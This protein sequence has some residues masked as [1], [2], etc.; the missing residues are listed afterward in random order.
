MKQREKLLELIR[1]LAEDD[2]E[3]VMADKVL[4]L[5][6][7]L[8]HANDVAIDIMD[9]ALSAHIKIL[10]YSCTQYREAQKSRWLG[11][12][13]EELKT[14]STWVLPALKQIREICCLYQEA[15]HNTA[16]SAHHAQ[17]QGSST[18]YR[19][20]V[21]NNLQLDH[22][23][24]ILVADNLTSY[25]D[26]VR[27]NPPKVL[28]GNPEDLYPDGRYNHVIQVQE[29]LNFLRFL[30]KDGQLWLCA[31]QAKQIWN[32][33]AENAVFAQDREACFKWFSKLMGDEPDLDPEINRD[34]FENNI[35][36]LD[37]SLMTESGIKC[38][39]RFFKEV[40]RKE[41][42][43]IAKRRAYLMDDLELIGMDYIWR[44]VL[45]SNEEIANKAIELLKETFT[46]LGPRLQ[47]NQV[48]I[49]ED[50]ISSCFDRLKASYD[51][52][53]LL[54]QE[55]DVK[56]GQEATKLCRVLK[57]LHEYVQECDA[58]FCDERTLVPLFRASRGKQL[59]LLFRFP[60][61]GRQMDDLEIYT[62]TNDTLASVKRQ[63]IQRLKGNPSQIKVE[64]KYEGEITDSADDRKILANL[65]F[66]D[67]TILEGKLIP[68]NHNSSVPAS[69]PD[70]S[71]D[72]STSSP[73]H[74]YDGGPNVEVEQCLPGVIIAQER[75]YTAFLLQLADLGCSLG[76][77]SLRDAARAVLT[78]IPADSHTASKIR[79]LCT[80]QVKNPASNPQHGFDSLFFTTSSSQTLYNLEVC[81]SL[82][83]PSNVTTHE[84]A[85]DLQ[86]NIVKAKGIPAFMGMLTRN[87]FLSTAD[88][89][90]KQLAYLTVLKVCKLVFAVAGHSLVH[91]V[92]E[93]CQPDSTSS[94]SPS[95]HSQAVILQQAL[96][97]IPSPSQEV[98][99]RNI[100]QRLATQ[101]LEAGAQHMPNQANIT[102]IIRLAWA[103]AAGNLGLTNGSP[104]EL[105][106]PFKTNKKIETKEDDIALACE[107]IEVLA[108]AIALHPQCLESLIKDS[109]WHQFIID[110]TLMSNY[111]EI[112]ITA[113]DQFLLIATR[114]S[115]EQHPIR[116]F[117]TLLF[118]VLS[119]TA[120]EQADQSLEY[121]VLLTRLLS[122][123]AASNLNLNTAESLL[124]TEITWLKKIRENVRKS[125]SAGCHDNLLEGHMWICRDLLAFMSAEKKYD[126]GSNPKT[127]VHLVKDLVEDFIFPASKM[128]VIY[129]S[130]NKIPMGAVIPVCNTGT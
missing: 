11:K 43:L 96:H 44:L 30:L 75:T 66:K 106:E 111:R 95:V 49:H 22:A 33:L 34:F 26:Q 16:P 7:N 90:T 52:I 105:H 29:R 71:S 17:R 57:V 9:Q 27:H 2:K 40:N 109:S 36:Q 93:A 50:F 31:P 39:D 113:A 99:I 121:F 19:H 129:K 102:S 103:S 62:H 76:H 120:T 13:I 86:M 6:W 28:A 69:S 127:S 59:I 112:R 42:K 65:P 107:A 92:A 79:N 82:L 18:M 116:F 3:G 47:T 126:V 108:L 104:A 54:E 12:C 78:L 24:V 37:P 119:S 118:T 63:I 23:L 115:G 94:V 89:R 73:Q 15:P 55:K 77:T 58:D 100:S 35:L 83:M 68:I 32:C 67:K 21:I 80:E 84:K 124:N 64:L 130:S 4:N 97:Q 10:D 88:L 114:C 8:A 56:F 38:F 72:S 1:H 110:L 128:H 53:T 74:H 98:V 60:N 51:T 48:E 91:M 85:F 25:V 117:I 101:L 125:G 81:Y 5:F 46:N 61:Q 14:N 45:N 122:Y 41:N 123:A 87:D 20:E 70:S